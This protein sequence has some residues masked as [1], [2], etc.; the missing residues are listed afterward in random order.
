MRGDIGKHALAR[1]HKAHQHDRQVHQ[2]DE[3]G[4]DDL[5]AQGEKLAEQQ[6]TVG[7]H[8]AN[9]IDGDIE[10]AVHRGENK[11]GDAEHRQHP[12]RDIRNL[13]QRRIMQ[14]EQQGN[15]YARNAVDKH[16]IA[17]KQQHH[18]HRAQQREEAIALGDDPPCLPQRKS[19]PPQAH[20]NKPH[21]E[22]QQGRKH[23]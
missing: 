6:V 19:P 7:I 18:V 10:P 16:D 21:A 14:R 9:G 11:R 23:G 4:G 22:A 13:A 1:P 17:P 8:R 2:H 12:E 3:R 15:D 20:R 5:R